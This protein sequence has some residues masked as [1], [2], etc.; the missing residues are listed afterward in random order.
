MQPGA[1]CFVEDV[2]REGG[3]PVTEASGHGEESDYKTVD[4]QDG[5]LRVLGPRQKTTEAAK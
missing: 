5:D 2:S 4:W 3:L 1:R